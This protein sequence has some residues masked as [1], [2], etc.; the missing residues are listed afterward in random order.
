MR[1]Q[2]GVQLA[3]PHTMSR[4]L[5]IMRLDSAAASAVSPDMSTVARRALIVRIVSELAA[6]SALEVRRPLISIS[7]I[8]R[9]TPVVGRVKCVAERAMRPVHGL[10]K[11]ARTTNQL[12]APGKCHASGHGRRLP[13]E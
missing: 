12:S 2:H 4:M 3:P 10:S 8:A 11:P 7:S 1:T 13:V 6:C 5:A 9:Q